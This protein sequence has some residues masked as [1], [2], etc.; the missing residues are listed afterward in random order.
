M[1]ADKNNRI[2]RVFSMSLILPA[3]LVLLLFAGTGIR[4]SDEHITV[5]YGEQAEMPAYSASF[6]GA[7]LTDLV[8]VTD[9]INYDEPGAYEIRYV[10]RLFGIPAA[11]KTVS[12]QIVDI[13]SPEIVLPNG[14]IVFTR[15]GEEISMPEYTITDNHDTAEELQITF[16]TGFDHT[17]EG[18][19]DS[20]VTACDLAGNCS[21]KSLKYIV[22]EISEADFTPGVFDLFAYDSAH[23][24]SRRDGIYMS[25][26]DYDQLYFIGDSNYLI[27]GQYKGGLDPRRV[28]AR[29]AMSPGTFDKPAYFNN[30]EVIRNALELVRD[31]KPKAVVLHMGLSECGNGDPLVLAEMYAWRIDQLL[32]I[33]PDLQIIVSAITPVTKDTQEAAATQEQIN[34]ANYCLMKM[35]AQKNITMIYSSEVFFGE[36]GYGDPGHF[37]PDGYHIQG[38]DFQMYTDYVRDTAELRR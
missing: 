11:R 22:G 10:C 36:D 14:N 2:A 35:C 37:Q 15:I 20:T 25:K 38:G 1:K 3:A 7:D 29:Y 26:R 27:M 13:D 6:L 32:Q 9:N 18:T 17:S 24:I 5:V 16:E 30:K 33:D 34:R 4:V 31:L 23:V 19:Y 8:Q 28:I 21:M 12:V